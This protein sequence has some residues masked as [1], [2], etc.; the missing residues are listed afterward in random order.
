MTLAFHDIGPA[1]VET[2]RGRI[3]DSPLP[4]WSWTLDHVALYHETP[5]GW[6]EW[7]QAELEGTPGV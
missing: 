5:G 4:A 1:E 2:L 6:V 7:D 3:E